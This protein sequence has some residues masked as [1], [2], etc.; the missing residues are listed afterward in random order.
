MRNIFQT[1]SGEIIDL[2]LA[3]RVYCARLVQI[4]DITNYEYGVVVEIEKKG[5]VLDTT[6][7]NKAAAQFHADAIAIDLGLMAGG[8][9]ISIKNRSIRN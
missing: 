6:G 8:E 7:K 5:H 4:N 1:T 9:T 3:D 2:S